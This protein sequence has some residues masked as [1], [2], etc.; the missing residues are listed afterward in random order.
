MW[1]VLGFIGVL[2]NAVLHQVDPYQL[3]IP[4]HVKVDHLNVLE[5]SGSDVIITSMTQRYRTTC[6]ANAGSKFV[7]T[8]YYAP[9][10]DLQRS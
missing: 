4:L 9:R 8:V 1:S 3:P 7:T 2:I 10:V 6:F 5:G